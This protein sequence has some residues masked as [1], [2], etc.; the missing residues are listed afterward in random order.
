MKREDIK[1]KIKEILS[2][3][4]YSENEYELFL[5]YHLNEKIYQNEKL[6][7]NTLYLNKIKENKDKID[8]K[9]KTIKINKLI[10][11]LSMAPLKSE[12]ILDENVF[13]KNLR[14]FPNIKEFILIYTK[15][16][17]NKLE[18]LKRM[19]NG[20]VITGIKVDF[21]SGNNILDKALKN[22]KKEKD[23]TKEN[24]VIDLTLGTKFMTIYFYKLAIETGINSI[25]WKLSQLP[26]YREIKEKNS[27]ERLSRNALKRIPLSLSL[28]IVIEPRKENINVYEE[29]NNSINEW[30]FKG[31][32]SCYRQ[33]GNRN[34]ELFF[35][36]LSNIYSIEN[37]ITLDYLNFYEQVEISFEKLSISL[38]KNLEL[39]KLKDFVLIMLSLII[40]EETG[41][42][43]ISEEP[44]NFV[45]LEK[46]KNLFNI[47]A[48][49]ILNT[50]CYLF[51][52]RENIYYYIVIKYF[53]NKS[54]N[55]NDS[56]LFFL[57]KIR[58]NILKELYPTNKN[59]RN[60]LNKIEKNLAEILF[61]ENI[62]EDL[63]KI[64]PKVFKETV[65]SD[66]YLRGDI[67]FIEKYGVSLNIKNIKELNFVTKKGFKLIREL[68]ESLNREISGKILY[69]KLSQKNDR[70]DIDE[71][72]Q[73]KSGRF[74]TNLTRLKSKIK[75]FN[76]N[77]RETVKKEKSIIIPDI[78]I[79]EKLIS[80]EESDYK[81]KIKVNP[82]IYTLT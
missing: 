23:I 4:K 11:A 35:K 66:F 56:Y 32:E 29:I 7:L 41:Y 17:E 60:L 26:E 68:L 25:N 82:E 46:I 14:I 5:K 61:E 22:L 62:M 58:K 28:D 70:L 49:E 16:N 59:N 30:N 79:Y 13:N 36:E 2:P 64:M 80:K 51:D 37:L 15:E 3:L 63:D 50:A 34:L 52:Q 71:N 72:I 75:D 24:T 9:I 40:F 76:K 45:W 38:F 18:Q 74:K 53:D 43:E 6:D 12:N 48:G 42:E 78:I 67:L 27:Y 77:I 54:K 21:L 19:Y 44:R 20:I 39:E 1:F 31:V 81:H 33:L 57:R 69:G 55:K 73:R 65:N 10:G 47:T 8:K